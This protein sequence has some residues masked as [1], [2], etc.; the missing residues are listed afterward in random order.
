MKSVLKSKLQWHIIVIVLFMFALSILSWKLFAKDMG[1]AIISHFKDEET[2]VENLV[3]SETTKAVFK[4]DEEVSVSSG[5]YIS[6]LCKA[7]DVVIDK[8]DSRWLVFRSSDLMKIDSMLTYYALGEIESVQ[9]IGG[10]NNWLFFKSS[11]DGNSIADYEGTNP[12]SDKEMRAILQ[13]A[14]HTQNEI[15]NKGIEFVVIVAPNKE[16]IYSEYMPDSYTHSDISSTDR[17]IDYLDENGVNIISPKSELLSNHL[18]YQVYYSY[19]THWNQ[20]GAYIGV[21]DVLAAWSIDIPDLNERTVLTKN[22]KNN[23]HY[24]A[25]DDLAA[26]VGL[27]SVFDDEIEYEVEGTV[28]MDWDKYE[29]EQTASI[30][31][32]FVNEQAIVQAT[33]FL[34]GDSFRSSMIPALRETFSDVYVVQRSFYE[35]SMLDEIDPDY[36][37]SE[38]VER[39][40]S[41]IGYIDNLIK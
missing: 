24:G 30:I 26:V 38:Y 11:T 39:Y 3:A 40:S 10:A 35:S 2:V 18:D 13:T 4:T 19:D 37:I 9:V 12:Y 29:E 16:N 6:N 25:E 34:V 5:G 1:N 32:H 36:L 17:L 27:L 41:D 8:I 28:L 15:E 22:L 7:L 33:V 14:L 21:K 23:Y 31:S 20:L